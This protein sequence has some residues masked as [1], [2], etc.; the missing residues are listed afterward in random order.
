MTREERQAHIRDVVD[1]APLPSPE[2]L[3]RLRALLQLSAR[4]PAATATQRKRL[5]PAAV[6]A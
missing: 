6:A 1:S 5:A 3:D 4:T 2:D